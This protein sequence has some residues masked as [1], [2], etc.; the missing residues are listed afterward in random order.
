MEITREQLKSLILE[1]KKETRSV[2]LEAPIGPGPQD[3]ADAKVDELKGDIKRSLYH[4]GQQAQ[5]L[6]DILGDTEQLEPQLAAMVKKAEALLEKVFKNTMYEKQ[7]PKG[8]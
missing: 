1:V 3:M 8:R 4:M 5:Q 6:H 2:L 7:N